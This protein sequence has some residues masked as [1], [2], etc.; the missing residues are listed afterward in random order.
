MP[1]ALMGVSTSLTDI[2]VA[3]PLNLGEILVAILVAPKAIAKLNR[4]HAF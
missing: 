1:F 2:A 3:I 4:I